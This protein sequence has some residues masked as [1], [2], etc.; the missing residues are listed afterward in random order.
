[1]KAARQR[2][3]A[4]R[5]QLEPYEN[6]CRELGVHPAEVALAW[7]LANPVV[8]T[9]VVGALTIAEL[10]ADLAALSVSLEADVLARLD[11]IWP[12]PGE[13][14]RGLRLVTRGDRAV[15][16]D[17]RSADAGELSDPRL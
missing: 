14:P 8:A 10:H 9:T 12:G 7:L 16:G 1:M 6:L 4:H 11:Q 13:A 17:P 5:G 15:A 3:E 2:I